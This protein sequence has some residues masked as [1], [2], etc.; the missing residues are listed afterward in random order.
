MFIRLQIRIFTE[1]KN[2]LH[3]D[4]LR[5]ISNAFNRFTHGT[6]SEMRDN[7]I[8]NHFPVDLQHA[9]Y[10]DIRRRSGQMTIY[11][12][13]DQPHRISTDKLPQIAEDVF[14]W[15]IREVLPDEVHNYSLT[16]TVKAYA[17]N[18]MNI[19]KEATK[20]AWHV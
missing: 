8:R 13:F 18:N 17:D 14:S 19:W 7:L 12:D 2:M 6:Y 16:V 9:K 11:I 20:G 3:P 1:S 5:A 15:C 10:A 4:T